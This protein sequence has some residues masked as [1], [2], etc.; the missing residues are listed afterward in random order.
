MYK[1]NTPVNVWAGLHYGSAVDK[2]SIQSNLKRKLGS[3]WCPCI[4]RP[5]SNLLPLKN[6]GSNVIVMFTNIQAKKKVMA[7]GGHSRAFYCLLHFPSTITSSLP[8]KAD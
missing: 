5:Q 1:C 8:L 6:N 3:L 7:T 2:C 4:P